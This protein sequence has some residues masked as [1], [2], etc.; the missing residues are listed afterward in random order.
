MEIKR[1]VKITFNYTTTN[2][3]C[4]DLINDECYMVENM[5]INYEDT[6]VIMRIINKYLISGSN[7]IPKE[8]FIKNVEYLGRKLV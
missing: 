8:I 4:K 5:F 2:T 3:I 1:L 7:H 6:S